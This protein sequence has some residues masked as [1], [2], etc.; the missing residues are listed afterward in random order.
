MAGVMRVTGAWVQLL[1]DWLEAE[2]LA[3]PA[4][5]AVISRHVH[6]DA[7]PVPVWRDLLSRAIALRPEQAAPELA[8][9]ALVQ[10][11]HVGVLGYL[12][13]A[14]DTLGEALLAYQRYERLF[15]GVDLA[16]VLAD[17]DDIEIR[18]SGAAAPLGQQG[19]GVAIA[20]LV[21]FLRRRVDQPPPL[22][23]VTFVGAAPGRAGAQAYREFFDCPVRFNDSHISVRFPRAYLGIPMPH[24]D[25]GLRAI[26]DRQA[27]ALLDALPDSDDFERALQQVLV[28]LLAEGAVTLPRVADALHLSVRTLQRRL[29]LRRLT[30]QELLDR[31][32]EELARGYLEDRSLALKDIALLLGFSEQSAFSR[33]F[34]R[35]TGETPARVRAGSTSGRMP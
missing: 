35:W 15:Y 20:A 4:I 1:G 5:R 7:V 23:R 2:G 30:W 12:V 10:A 9:G 11:R 29:D 8:I 19:D 17:G 3:A 24:A 32:R 33:A 22:R 27:A 14:S 26:L 31:T 28:R 21:S 18:W 16:E 13:L 6:D 25:P 34:R